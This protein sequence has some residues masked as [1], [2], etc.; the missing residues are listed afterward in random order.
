H[1]ALVRH[2]LRLLTRQPAFSLF[3]ILT[4]GLGIGAATAVFT[5]VQSVLLNEL[6]FSEPDRLVWMYNA[7]TERDRAPFSIAD[8]DDYARENTTLA[9]L[10]PFT[11]FAANLTGSGE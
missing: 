6:P 9:G 5:L 2:A 8:L 10:A 4:L 11:N 3:T 1:N 7:R